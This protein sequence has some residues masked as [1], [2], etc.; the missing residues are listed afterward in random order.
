[1]T[2]PDSRLLGT[3]EFGSILRDVRRVE[4]KQEPSIDELLRTC[5]QEAFERGRQAGE[6]A[7]RES[8]LEQRTEFMTLQRGVFAHLRNSIPEVLAQ[9]EAAMVQ[10]AFEVA[11]RLVAGVPI[12]MEMVQGV[13]REAVGELTDAGRITVHLHPEDLE[14]L[15]NANAPVLNEE[16]AGERLEFEPSANVTRGGCILRT[17]FGSV[18]ARRETK[19]EQLRQ[20]VVS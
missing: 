4:P 3:I 1:M 6:L 14:L 2:R 8:L 5:E 19:I 12:S 9:C 11:G 15:Q 18:D 13:V 20:A 17:R 10:L 7:L 16:I